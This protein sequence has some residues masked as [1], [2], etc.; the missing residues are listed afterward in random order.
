[1]PTRWRL[2]VKYVASEIDECFIAKEPS[3]NILEDKYEAFIAANTSVRFR[4]A[5]I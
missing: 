2:T 4:I 1:M 3:V 5:R